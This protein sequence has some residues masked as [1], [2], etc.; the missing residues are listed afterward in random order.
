MS[1]EERDELKELTE[2]ELEGAG[3]D[4]AT[5]L[6]SVFDLFYFILAGGVAFAVAAGWDLTEQM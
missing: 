6:L 2:F 4:E 1:E 3:F 5:S